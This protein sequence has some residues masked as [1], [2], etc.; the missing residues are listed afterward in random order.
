MRTS[1]QR[2]N[3]MSTSVSKSKPAGGWAPPSPPPPSRPRRPCTPP[4]QPPPQPP[5]AKIPRASAE[6]TTLLTHAGRTPRLGRRRP[7]AFYPGRRGDV[8]RRQLLVALQRAAARGGLQQPAWPQSSGSLGPRCRATE[9]R[10]DWLG[11]GGRCLTRTGVCACVCNF[12]K[13]TCT[14]RCLI[15]DEGWGVLESG[16]SFAGKR[17][18][19]LF[20]LVV[21]KLIVRRTSGDAEV[22]IW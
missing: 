2:R 9:Q 11:S 8:T 22:R 19:N 7:Q 3:L 10:G 6:T 15:A 5:P 16:G 4:Q 1:L 17:F 12:D 18:E 20:L 14:S 21:V 13:F